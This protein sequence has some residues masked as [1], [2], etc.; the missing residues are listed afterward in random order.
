MRLPLLSL[1]LCL[2]TLRGVALAQSP[3][4]E[5][6]GRFIEECT[7]PGETRADDVV[8]RHANAIQLSAERWLVIYST[9]GYRGVDDERSI[10]YQVRAER[11]DGRVLKEG[12]LSRTSDDWRPEG[13][14]AAPAG[15][16][17]V[18]QHGHMVAFG[19]PRGALVAGQPAASANCFA[20]MWRVLGRPLD[21]AAK[22]LDKT[23]ED[24]ALFNATRG[25][26][27]CQFRL[28]DASDDIELTQPVRL[29]R[30]QGFE[31]GDVFCEHSDA[32]WINQSFC[33]PV[34][35]NDAKTEW[36]VAD[37]FANRRIA[38][39]QLRFNPASK[40]YE[41]VKTGPFIGNA[42]TPFWEASLLRTGREWIVA[43]RSNGKVVWA[44]SDDPFRGWSEPEYSE[45][46]S[47]NA[48]L[49]AFQCADGL[50][51]LF[52]GDRAASPQ[53]YDRD[54]L[55]CWEV[56][57][58]PHFVASNRRVIFDSREAKL[59][60]RP[61]VRSKVDFCE[62]FPLHGQTQLVVFGVSTRG[63]NFPYEK[64]SGIPAIVQAEKDAAGLYYAALTYAKPV[65]PMWRFP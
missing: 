8:P 32:G 1:A 4:P 6:R 60:I 33:P 18:K 57:T 10:V 63:Y 20:A 38:A 15:Q 41:W 64:T 7:L 28:N 61:E 36:A 52:T 14:A 53:K 65:E 23:P 50:V 5:Y 35:A 43:A 9:H 21:V 30:Q 56:Q 31:K 48:P 3:A 58:Q 27:W 45:E 2:C 59:P 16:A 19:V 22:R 25:I 40:L 29:F 49:T 37:H 24:S 44:R 17:Y 11:P 46:P 13:L 54:P 42:R 26:E 12:F 55:Y 39:V 62:L 51:R 47:V 34:A